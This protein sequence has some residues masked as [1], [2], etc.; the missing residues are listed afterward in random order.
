[1]SFL[2]PDAL[3]CPGLIGESATY[4]EIN[5]S[6]TAFLEPS[7]SDPHRYLLRWWTP[8]AEVAL[9]G[10]ATLASTAALTVLGRPPNQSTSDYSFDTKYR[11]TLTGKVLPS[12]AS[13]SSLGKFELDFPADPP[14]EMTD[15]AEK[16]ALRD[17]VDKAT[18]GKVTI[19]KFWKSS[20]DAVLEVD[21][22]GAHL[23]DVEVQ[24][25]MLVSWREYVSRR[26]PIRR[27]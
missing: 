9:C 10:H 27:I 2:P 6:E 19:T 23:G 13:I 16:K 18:N 21:C 7:S 14:V 12:D 26:L 3:R 24:S 25:G 20:D 8:S 11:G 1:V 15:E 22:H 5:L 17:A 4:S